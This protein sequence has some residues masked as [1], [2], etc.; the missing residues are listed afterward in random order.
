[1]IVGTQIGA[2]IAKRTKA[3]VLEK[4]LGICIL[5]VGARMIMAGL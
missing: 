1:M 3:N 5:V 4:L 2:R